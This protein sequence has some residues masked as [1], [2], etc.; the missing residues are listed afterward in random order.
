MCKYEVKCLKIEISQNLPVFLYFI[1]L[2]LNEA[3]EVNE[4]KKTTLLDT[5]SQTRKRSV[6]AN[7]LI[8]SAKASTSLA[9]VS[10]ERLAFDKEKFEFDKQK[11]EFEKH[12]CERK[13]HI[14]ERQAKALEDLVTKF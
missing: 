2:Q 14:M 12:Y 11:F 6:A 3:T 7:R 13:L 1:L 9:N 4:E 10:E 5:P 8:T